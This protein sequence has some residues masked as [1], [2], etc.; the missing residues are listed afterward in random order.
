M[1]AQFGAAAAFGIVT[2]I[3][4]THAHSEDDGDHSHDSNSS[5]SET[6]DV[7]ASQPSGTKHQHTHE[8]SIS[9]NTYYCN[10]ASIPVVHFEH[11]ASAHAKPIDQRAP[12]SPGLNS[13]F[14]PPIA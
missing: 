1:T 9:G 14:R 13:I 7:Q 8:V 5:H 2:K 10:Q 3:S 12:Q 6:K 4:I 11:S